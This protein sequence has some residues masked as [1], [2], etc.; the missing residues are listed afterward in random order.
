MYDDAGYSSQTTMIPGSS[1]FDNNDDDFG[2]AF[3]EPDRRVQWHGGVDFGLLVLRLALGGAFVVHGLDKLFGWF[4]DAGGMGGIEQMLT[5]YGFTEPKILAWVLALSETVGG[6]L[7][8]LGL[9]TPVAAAA[10]LGVMANV[11][12]VKGDWNVFMG[13][14]ELEMVYA[15]MAFVLLFT[16]A[17]RAAVDRNTHWCRKAPIYGI[18]FLLLAAGASAVT[19]FVFR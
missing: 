3:D 10:V 13:G 18:P 17:G 12:A 8:V 5:G 4:T 1:R 15:A 14:V 9:F 7:L 2:G 16:G 11:I 6:A 19:L